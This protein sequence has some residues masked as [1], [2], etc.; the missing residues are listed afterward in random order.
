MFTKVFETSRASTARVGAAAAVPEKKFKDHLPIDPP[1]SLTRKQLQSM[2][3]D[4]YEEYLEMISEIFY[5]D[6]KE[7]DL[8][9][10]H[11][12]RISKRESEQRQVSPSSPL[13]QHHHHHSRTV[14]SR[15]TSSSSSLRQQVA[16]FQSHDRSESN[17]MM[18]S[19]IE[20]PADNTSPH[21]FA[22][23]DVVVEVPPVPLPSP[24]AIRSPPPTIVT[25]V[26]YTQPLPDQTPILISKLSECVAVRSRVEFRLKAID[27]FLTTGKSSESFVATLQ[28]ISS[29]CKAQIAATWEDQVEFV[30]SL[31]SF[32]SH[33][34]PHHDG[35]QHER[36]ENES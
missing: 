20:G 34:S 26:K 22:V 5:L 30:K 35:Q 19:A 28:Y 6:E 27:N 24:V 33:H 17:Q 13:R 12:L 32:S 21:L 29:L 31:S 23:E 1:S 18:T 36:S 14:A 7:M 16:P 4:D 3:S 25:P 2:S 11:R 15:R 8:I 9:R 10:T